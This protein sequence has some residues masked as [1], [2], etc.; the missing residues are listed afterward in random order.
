MSKRKLLTDAD[1]QHIALAVHEAGHAVVGVLYGARVEHA[2]LARDRKSGRC[3]F[4]ADSFGASPSA[5][6]PQIAAAGALAEAV[7]R[8]GPRPTIRQIEALLN[9]SD[10]EELRFVAL[11]SLQPFSIPSNAVLPMVLRCWTAIG[12]LATELC[13]GHEIDHADVCAALGL[14]D[15]GGPGSL[16]LAMIRSG[17]APGTFT[18]TRAVM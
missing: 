14:T 4:D 15:E 13:L 7:F 16:G 2:A 12:D 18:V 6:R 8:H 1:R 3:E 11:S 5:Y 9:G 17:S 10:C